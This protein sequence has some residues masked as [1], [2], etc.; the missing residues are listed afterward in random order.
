VRRQRRQRRRWLWRADADPRAYV[1]TG[2]EPGDTG[3]DRNGVDTGR[4]G[5]RPDTGR[6]R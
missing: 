4:H 5:D 3:R 1:D 6:D 2:H